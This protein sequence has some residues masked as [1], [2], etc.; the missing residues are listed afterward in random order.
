MA[1]KLISIVTTFRNEAANLD[2]LFTQIYANLE[3][4]SEEYEFILV[5][6]A[7]SKIKSIIRNPKNR[8]S[9]CY[10]NYRHMPFQFFKG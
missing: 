8:F 2:E 4:I 9:V 6:V 1:P 10:G 3:G 7:S 5:D